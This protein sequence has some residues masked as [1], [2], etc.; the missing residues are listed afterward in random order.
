MGE[1]AGAVMRWARDKKTNLLVEPNPGTRAWCPHCDEDVHAKC[2]EVLDW[3]WSHTGETCE[4]SHEGGGGG[5]WLPGSILP[6]RGTCPRCEWWQRGCTAGTVAAR[7]WL[8]AY[9]DPTSELARVRRQAPQCPSAV[10]VRYYSEVR[11]LHPTPLHPSQ[12][13]D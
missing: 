5:G 4:E 10:N 6:P 3:H 2:G 9:G 13:I 1:G 11:R 12:V 7:A 8:V